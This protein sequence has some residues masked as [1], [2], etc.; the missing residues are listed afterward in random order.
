VARAL[1]THRNA[2]NGEARSDIDTEQWAIEHKLRKTIPLWLWN[3]MAQAVGAATDAQRPLVIL[4]Q[5][6]RG[7]KAKRLVVMQF[8]DFVDL[9]AGL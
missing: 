4:T 6:S 5:S 3:A 2:N 9:M 8:D 7:R 1:G